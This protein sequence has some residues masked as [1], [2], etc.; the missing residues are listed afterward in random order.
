M[1][2]NRSVT[3]IVAANDYIGRNV[4]RAAES[5]KLNIPKDV[6]ITGFDAASEDPGF[7]PPLTSAKVDENEMAKLGSGKIIEAL[8]MRIRLP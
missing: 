2:K 5:L 7:N 1:L 8:A 6:S 4:I 3:A